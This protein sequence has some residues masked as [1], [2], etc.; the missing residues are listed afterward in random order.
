[1]KFNYLATVLPLG[2]LLTLAGATPIDN[3]NLATRDA[4]DAIPATA[5]KDTLK[6]QTL[7]ISFCLIEWSIIHTGG[8]RPLTDDEQRVARDNCYGCGQPDC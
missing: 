5:N 6:R 2:L 1:M 3:A 7:D 8:D 4:G